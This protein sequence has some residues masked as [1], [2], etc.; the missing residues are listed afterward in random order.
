MG[1]KVRSDE[2]LRKAIQ[3]YEQSQHA[4]N[5][6]RDTT[7]ALQQLLDDIDK[8]L[9]EDGAKPSEIRT[10]AEQCLA[11]EMSLTPDQILDLARQINATMATI[12]NIEDILTKTASDLSQA[13]S[14]K[15]HADRARQ[16]SELY[17]KRKRLFAYSH[18]FS[19]AR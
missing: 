13:Q 1:A 17:C 19:L 16:V 5:T 10:I 14:L 12:T 7:T 18:L 4:K 9:E 8:F 15:S 6:S 11:M 3:A 2:A